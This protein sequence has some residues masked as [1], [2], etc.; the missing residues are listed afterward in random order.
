[1]KNSGRWAAR[2]Q[3]RGWPRAEEQGAGAARLAGLRRARTETNTLESKYLGSQKAAENGPILSRSSQA[4]GKGYVVDT[5]PDTARVPCCPRANLP[6][7]VCE[8]G[9]AGRK[10]QRPRQGPD[11][12]G[13]GCRAPR[14]TGHFP[15]VPWPWPWGSDVRG[16]GVRGS[17][18]PGYACTH[19]AVCRPQLPTRLH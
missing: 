18:A 4:L 16:V 11:S 1:M 9:R 3:G 15:S 2:S 12:L 6:G 10:T 5:S 17:R 7:R 19:A 13:E 8:A 14:G